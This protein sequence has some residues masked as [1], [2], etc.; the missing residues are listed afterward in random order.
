M[1]DRGRS[2]PFQVVPNHLNSWTAEQASKQQSS[3]PLHQLLPNRLL[4][5]LSSCLGF[6]QWQWYE[7]VGQIHS[8]LPMLLWT[9]CFTTAKVMRYSSNIRCPILYSYHFL[10]FIQ[11]FNSYIFGCEPSCFL[12]VCFYELIF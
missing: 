11:D 9:W 12:F 5:C 4:L 3:W 6:L 10:M 1:I 7:R 8:R 2:S